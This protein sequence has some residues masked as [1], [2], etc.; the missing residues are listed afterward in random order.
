MYYAAQRSACRIP[1][2]ESTHAPVIGQ[3][4][5]D[6]A[7]RLNCDQHRPLASNYILAGISRQEPVVVS[8]TVDPAV[9]LSQ[10]FI[11]CT[12]YSSNPPLK[13]RNK[14]LLEKRRRQRINSALDELKNLMAH[15]EP[16]STTP[17]TKTHL[18]LEKANILEQVVSFVKGAVSAAQKRGAIPKADPEHNLLLVRTEAFIQGFSFCE[19]TVTRIFDDILRNASH[20]Q[21]GARTANMT[22]ASV[23][24]ESDV[25]TFVSAVLFELSHKHQ[26]VTTAIFNLHRNSS[27]SMNS[28]PNLHIHNPPLNGAGSEVNRC[29]TT[30]RK[31]S[32]RSPSKRPK[33]MNP[34]TLSDFPTQSDSS[35]H[36]SGSSDRGSSSSAG[37][38]N[39]PHSAPIW[40]PW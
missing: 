9:D 22:C 29:A 7:L 10:H 19:A 1:L 39:V 34:L 24:G 32:R 25:S 6:C 27:T 20:E 37:S 2:N 30:R 4:A 3:S 23:V 40:R 13:K 5:S 33:G 38:F 18:K 11:P 15:S 28:D 14:P 31:T 17:A 8:N 35:H 12:G 26:E 36:S 21:P 16:T